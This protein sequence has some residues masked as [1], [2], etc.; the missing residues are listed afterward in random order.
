MKI[1][2]TGALSGLGYQYA[3]KLFQ[4]GHIVYAGVENEKQKETLENKIKEEKIILFPTIINLLKEETIQNIKNL[5]LDIIILQAGIAEGGSIYEIDMKRIEQNYQVNIFGN[6]KLIKYF[7]NDIETKR[8]RGKIFITSSLAAFIPIPYLS[9]YT[10]TKVS[11]YMI[12]RT[13][14]LEVK[15]QKI[16]VSISL[17]MPG[18]YQTGFNEVF[19]ENKMKDIVKKKKAYQMSKYQR[20]IFALTESTNY[21]SIVNKLIKNIEK[22]DPKFIISAPFSQK[23]LT[24]LMIIISTFLEL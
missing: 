24:K 19:I 8:K 13:L 23:M 12:A 14:R 21:D 15:Y 11:L 16:P 4:R 20:I 9:S 22:N 10:A 5:D 7:L 2:I 17:I 3:K 18:A 1:L 6:L